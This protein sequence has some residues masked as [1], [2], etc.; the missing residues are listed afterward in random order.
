MPHIIVQHTKEVASMENSTMLG[1]LREKLCGVCASFLG[2]KDR[3][4]TK[5]D[6][7]VMFF[8]EGPHDFLIKDIQ[9]I[10][11]AHADPERVAKSD[12][13]AES[14][15]TAIEEAVWLAAPP[16]ESTLVEYSVSLHLG[17]MGYFANSEWLGGAHIEA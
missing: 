9:V 12:E 8:E 11:L 3:K 15:A 4:L 1:T 7:S 2:V 14:I 17:E 13:L 16:V 10:I 6:F 5:N